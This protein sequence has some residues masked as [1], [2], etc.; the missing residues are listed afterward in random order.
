MILALDIHDALYIFI[1]TGDAERE[2]EAIDVQEDRFEFCDAA[3]QPYIPEYTRL[4]K[5]SSLSVDIGSFM[6]RREGDIK[7]DLPERFIQR[8]RHIEH[9]SITSLTDIETLLLELHRGA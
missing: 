6:L 1:D 4:P 5:R 8:A 2:L 9:S 7:A 3:G